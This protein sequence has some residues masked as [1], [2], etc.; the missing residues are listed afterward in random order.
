MSATQ[1]L[2][3]RLWALAN[4]SWENKATQSILEFCG[5]PEPRALHFCVLRRVKF[6]CLRVKITALEPKAQSGKSDVVKSI[7]VCP[8]DSG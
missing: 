7:Y 2:G 1:A 5:S 8:Q 6:A 4:Q 3:S